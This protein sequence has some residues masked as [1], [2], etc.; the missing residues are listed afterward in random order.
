LRVFINPFEPK[1]SRPWVRFA[2]G[3][4]WSVY[5]N[6]IKGCHCK[7]LETAVNEY[8]SAVQRK[9]H[10]SNLGN[11]GLVCHSEPVQGLPGWGDAVRDERESRLAEKAN[12]ERIAK[13]EAEDAAQK[14]AKETEWKT[15]AGFDRKRPFAGLFA[16]LGMAA[17]MG[18]FDDLE[19]DEA[20]IEI[21]DGENTRQVIAVLRESGIMKEVPG[22]NS[23]TTAG[24]VSIPRQLGEQ[25][26]LDVEWAVTGFEA[27]TGRVIVEG[28]QNGEE[29]V[30]CAK[31]KS[32]PEHQP[33]P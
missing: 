23:G 10:L 8:N 27:G 20:P 15:A 3:N 1:N 6:Q 24:I 22:P 30:S 26:A 29:A 2:P 9:I 18:A 5:D 11:M 14:A 28:P 19:T 25:F 33:E 32:F 4:G 7:Q 21:V 31:L 17:A 13:L 16:L 12:R